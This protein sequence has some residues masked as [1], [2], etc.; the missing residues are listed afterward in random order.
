[1]MKCSVSYCKAAEAFFS[2]KPDY[3]I[4]RKVSATNQTVRM[5]SFQN[6]S[7]RIVIQQVDSKI[8]M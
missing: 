5:L 8:V 3:A 2:G 6:Q 7:V 4:I 1:M